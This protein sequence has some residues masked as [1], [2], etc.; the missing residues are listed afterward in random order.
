MSKNANPTLIGAFVLGAAALSVVLVVVLSAGRLFQKTHRFVLIFNESISGLDVGAPVEYEGVRVG[1]V[2]DIRLYSDLERE[3]LFIPV[4]MQIEPGRITYIG[5]DRQIRTAEE[6]CASF[7]QHGLACQLQSQ[8][9][10]TGKKK[11]QIVKKDPATLPPMTDQRLEEIQLPTVRSSLEEI[12][13]KLG[14][15][16]LA[17]IADQVNVTM[18]GISAL[19]NSPALQQAVT[20]ISLTLGEVAT[21]AASMRQTLSEDGEL[22][23][24]VVTALTDISEAADSIKELGR[25][26]NDQ[27]LPNTE[28]LLADSLAKMV[29]VLD[30]MTGVLQR[31]RPMGRDAYETLEEFRAT[32]QAL[33][34]A[35]EYVQQNPDS[36]IKGKSTQ[37]N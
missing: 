13:S 27:T 17:A 19:V 12:S 37:E 15:M 32:A 33:R 22:M 31:S 6:L 7:I 14:D 34:R 9:F 26:L 28:R 1:T 11:I 21:L 3:E 8:S 24:D 30:E 25:Q 4:F 2:T 10:V 16:P 36:L 29:E 35:L 5:S 20:N 18:E 23:T